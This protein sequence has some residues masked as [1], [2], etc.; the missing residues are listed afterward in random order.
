MLLPV[1]VA[2]DVDNPLLGSLGASRVYGPQ[3]GATPAQVKRL[4]AGLARL[5]A[6]IN[7]DLGIDIAALPG[8][9]AGGGM[10]AGLRAFLGGQ[11]LPGAELVLDSL[12]IEKRLAGAGLFLT[13]E[14]SLDHQSL[15]GKAPVVAGRMAR[16]AGVRSVA[17]VG[18]LGQG[19]HEAI[20]EA[21]DAVVA[22]DDGSDGDAEQQL[23]LASARLAAD[24]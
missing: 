3:K 7:R 15:R 5:A 14:G 21:F 12:Q 22:L 20:D 16:R 10:G 4:E 23:R 17:L 18:R 24:L 11:L 9:G 2:V 19:W 13:G 6:V 1:L 8:G